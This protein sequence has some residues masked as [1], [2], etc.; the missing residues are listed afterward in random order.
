MKKGMLN[1]VKSE[2]IL[3]SSGKCHL[4]LTSQRLNQVYCK[5]KC[6]RPHFFSGA[7]ILVN[8][9]EQGN[10]VQFISFSQKGFLELI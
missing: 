1:A 8:V 6:K 9:S 4:D 3:H 2:T 10:T 7:F 5:M